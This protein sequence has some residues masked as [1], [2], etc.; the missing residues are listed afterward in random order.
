MTRPECEQFLSEPHVGIV[1]IADGDRGPLVCPV[2]YTYAAG[3]VVAFC[4][5]KDAR[6]ARLLTTSSRVSFLVQTEGD[7]I[8]GVLPRY[9]V[10]EGPVVKLE[11]ADMDRD[12]RPVMHRYLGAEVGDNYLQATRGDSAD[13]EL[14]VHIRPQ[15]WRSRDFGA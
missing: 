8:G 9:V 12:L 7:L 11:T 14:V 1:T 4:T 6:Q 10:V 3:G 15:R 13:G 5:K 2:W